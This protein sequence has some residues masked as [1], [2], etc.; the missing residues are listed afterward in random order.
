[1]PLPSL[2]QRLGD[3][4][5]CS[6]TGVEKGTEVPNAGTYEADLRVGVGSDRWILY[7]PG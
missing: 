6:A 3:D 1:M 2:V 4:S 7:R 5:P